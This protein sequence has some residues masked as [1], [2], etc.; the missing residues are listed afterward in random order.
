MREDFKEDEEFELHGRAGWV[1]T[2]RE[3]AGSHSECGSNVKAM[4]HTGHPAP[5]IGPGR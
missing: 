4:C 2:G 3:E 5:A 1:W